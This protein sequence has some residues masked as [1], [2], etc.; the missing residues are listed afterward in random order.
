MKK[1]RQEA[2][3]IAG[4]TMEI[5]RHVGAY[6]LKPIRIYK[7]TNTA[8]CT[9]KDVFRLKKFREFL[10]QRQSD[11]ALYN[12]NYNI[13]IL[14]V[15]MCN[16][17]YLRVSKLKERHQSRWKQTDGRNHGPFDQRKATNSKYTYRPRAHVCTSFSQ[18]ST[19]REKIAF[20]VAGQGGEAKIKDNGAREKK[21]EAKEEKTA[22]GGIKNKDERKRIMRLSPRREE[23]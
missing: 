19:N 2:K 21:E 9:I 3:E 18:V 7:N 23:R 8:N 16:F 20:F 13:H 15:H 10:S 11:V 4:R 22:E 12:V 1:F 5:T 6:S 17:T 14:Q